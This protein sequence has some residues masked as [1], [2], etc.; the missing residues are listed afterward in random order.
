MMWPKVKSIDCPSDDD[1]R[2]PWP[3]IPPIHCALLKQLQNPLCTIISVTDLT[4]KPGVCRT[5]LIA[6]SEWYGIS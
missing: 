4:I 5:D 2:C 1:R 6:G 3:W